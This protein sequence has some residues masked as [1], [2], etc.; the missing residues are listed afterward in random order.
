[1]LG[2]ALQFQEIFPDILH[3]ELI[4]IVYIFGGGSVRGVDNGAGGAYHTGTLL[5]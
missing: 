1:M 3:L 2:T 4:G 5:L